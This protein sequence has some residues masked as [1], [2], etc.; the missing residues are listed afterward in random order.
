M[1]LLP[2]HLFEKEA[3][4]DQ[5]GAQRLPTGDGIAEDQHGAEDGEEFSSGGENRTGQRTEPF[6]REKDEILS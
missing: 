2:V 4:E 6:N 3:K 1:F 5:H